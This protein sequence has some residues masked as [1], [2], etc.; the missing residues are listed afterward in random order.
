MTSKRLLIACATLVC[1]FVIAVQPQGDARHFA[2]EGLTFDYANGWTISDE[3]NS[4]AQQLTLN[5]ANSDAQLRVFAHRGKVDTPE[6]FAQAK[7]AFIEPYL[8]SVNDT[9]VQ[10]GVSPQST[11]AAIEIGGAQAEGVRL[12]ASLGG[13]PGEADVFWVTLGNR[14]VI[15]TFFG[16]DAELRKAT[17]AW[18][19]IRNSIKIEPPPPKASPTKKP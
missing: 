8:K 13:E 9:F 5:R 17:P 11:P 7:K 10:M 14:V 19:L 3:S 12:K 15:L 1:L 2:K 16:P 18:D 4:D 6:K